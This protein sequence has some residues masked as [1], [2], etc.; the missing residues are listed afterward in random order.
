VNRVVSRERGHLLM[1]KSCGVVSSGLVWGDLFALLRCW[2]RFRTQAVYHE[3]R[4][5]LPDK[6]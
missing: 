4:I 1:F 5:N 2:V 3:Y 6:Q